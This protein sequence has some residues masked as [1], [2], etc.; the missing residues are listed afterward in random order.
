MRAGTG[1]IQKEIVE[2]IRRNWLERWSCDSVWFTSIAPNAKSLA[3]IRARWLFLLAKGLRSV[4]R[5]I[6]EIFPSE[7]IWSLG[8]Q[9]RY[10]DAKA[11]DVREYKTPSPC[12]ISSKVA[13]EQALVTLAGFTRLIS[14]PLSNTFPIKRWTEQIADHACK[15]SSQGNDGIVR[16]G[17]GFDDPIESGIAFLTCIA[18]LVGVFHAWGDGSD[19][20]IVGPGL[21]QDQR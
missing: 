17:K 11:S 12:R 3:D 14:S 9:G 21:L 20:I 5:Q 6:I 18:F 15:I 1:G 4:D 13:R 10:A 2:K 16:K 8:I 19:G 7:A